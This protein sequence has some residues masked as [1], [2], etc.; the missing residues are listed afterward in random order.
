MC[1][2]QNAVAGH[3]RIQYLSFSSKVLLVGPGSVCVSDYTAPDHHDEAPQC[4]S[5]AEG[6]VDYPWVV[7]RRCYSKHVFEAVE[8]KLAQLEADYN[9]AVA[10]QDL[11]ARVM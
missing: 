6:T 11:T 10:K 4:P 8:D 7:S 2:E 1:V 5:R 3:G 9:A